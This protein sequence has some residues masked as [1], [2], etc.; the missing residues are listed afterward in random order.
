[1]VRTQNQKTGFA[2]E[3]PA[4]PETDPINANDAKYWHWGLDTYEFGNK[5]IQAEHT[6]QPIYRANSRT[7]AEL[8]LINK[9]VNDQ[10]I[11]FYPVNLLPFYLLYG[12]CSTAGSVHTITPIT[13]GSLPTF[14]SRSEDYGGTASQ[15]WTAVGCKAKAYSVMF[16]LTQGYNQ[17]SGSLVY[18]GIKI[19]NGAA[20]SLNAT[21]NGRK[22]PTADGLMSGTES[23]LPFKYDSNM[24][25]SWDAAGTPVDYSASL[26]NFTATIAS[27]KRILTIDN[28]AETEYINDGNYSITFGF[29]LIRGDASDIH[30][31]FLTGNQFD[32]TF[33]I[34]ASATRYIQLAFDD[35][36]VASCRENYAKLRQGS[37]EIPTYDVMGI[38][39][40]VAI[41]GRDDVAASMFGE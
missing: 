31:D 29:Q 38:A 26:L 32:F 25:F 5:H 37:G 12:D 7:P 17:M 9:A 39:E 33:K 23:K 28:Q 19:L 13:S 22:Y 6:W 3:N 16:D 11:A 15:Y 24:A 41:T 30:D 34:Y 36:G 14:T 8:S 40:D 21:H 1:M 27:A 10:T 35:V 18:D 20:C 4:T 2:I